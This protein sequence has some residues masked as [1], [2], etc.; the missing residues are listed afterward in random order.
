MIRLD[1]ATISS[2]VGGG[3]SGALVGAI[4]GGWV[5]IAGATLS[6]SCYA[7]VV[8]TNHGFVFANSATLNGT[9]TDKGIWASRGSFVS[10]DSVTISG[11]CRI[12]ISNQTGSNIDA[13]SAS[14]TG[15]TDYG[16][17]VSDGATGYMPYAS[18]SGATTGFYAARN[19]TLEA[20]G[21]TATGATVDYAPTI[22]T[23]GSFNS[24]IY[25]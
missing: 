16:I 14:V 10:A 15:A 20:F 21:S 23:L 2:V 8:S 12:G 5:S 6:G 13:E 4:T 24:Y 25:K 18:V 1:G 3:A 9:Y 17:A 19:A 11:S 22:N 7:G